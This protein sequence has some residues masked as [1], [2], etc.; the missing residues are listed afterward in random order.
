MKVVEK[1]DLI[2]NYYI[3]LILTSFLFIIIFLIPQISYLIESVDNILNN[4]KLDIIKSQPIEYS[5]KKILLLPIEN[6]LIYFFL[7]ASFLGYF[8]EKT[9]KA[10][11]KM[12]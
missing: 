3:N 7:L 6:G 1:N 4:T 8:L 11:N 5:I 9:I 12:K 2:F 10:K